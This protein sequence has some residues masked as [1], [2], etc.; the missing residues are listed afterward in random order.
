MTGEQLKK[1]ILQYAIEGKL[2]FQ[3]DKEE[4]ASILIEKIREEKERLAKEKIIR[5][6][7]DESYI[8]RK[9]GSFY[10]KIGK[11]EKCIDDELPFDIPDN[12]EWTRLNTIAYTKRAEIINNNEIIQNGFFP[13]VTQGKNDIDGYS[14]EEKKVIKELPIILFGDHTRNVQFINFPFIVAGDGAKLFR[15]IKISPKYFYYYLNF[16]TLKIK[17][18]G[19]ARHF[20]LLGKELYPI[21]PLLEQERIV[22][23]LEEILAKVEILKS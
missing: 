11:E 7:K 6:D 8:Y 17:N 15:T 21:P 9:D 18:R 12:W 2:V 22:A 16:L 3:D 14:N 13:V 19:Y 10:E 23:K 5:R 4:P 20:S 1:S